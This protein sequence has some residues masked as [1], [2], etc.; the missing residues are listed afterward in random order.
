[1][2]CN[3]FCELTVGSNAFWPIATSRLHHA[4]RS[5]SRVVAARRAS[6]SAATYCVAERGRSSGLYWICRGLCGGYARLGY[7]E[8]RNFSMVYRYADGYAERLPA[9]A[10]ELVRLKSNVILAG[11]TRVQLLDIC[12]TPASK[13]AA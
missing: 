6:A 5:R 2:L 1:M 8:S 3:R 10:D 12:M 7:V 11:R 4:G 13:I 9:L